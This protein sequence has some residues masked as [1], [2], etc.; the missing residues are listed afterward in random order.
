MESILILWLRRRDD[1]HDTRTVMSTMQ[2]M[3]LPVCVSWNKAS[4]SGK[5]DKSLEFEIH[6][7]HFRNVHERGC[8]C[9][10]RREARF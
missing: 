1:A 9:S 10:V 2:K 3:Q 6:S 5:F 4:D 7:S 8:A